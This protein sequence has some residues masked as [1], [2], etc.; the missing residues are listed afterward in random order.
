MGIGF[1]DVLKRRGKRYE[2]Q[3]GGMVTRVWILTYLIILA[4][5]NDNRSG[6]HHWKGQDERWDDCG[7]HRK[8]RIM[9]GG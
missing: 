5:S 8:V 4:C 9:G 2:G 1:N 7:T 6:L 3:Y